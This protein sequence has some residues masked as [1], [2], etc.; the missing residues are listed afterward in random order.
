MKTCS[1]IGVCLACFC[2]LGITATAFSDHDR[3]REIV[4]RAS[5]RGA[6]EV[7]PVNSPATAR[8]RATIHD[9]GTIDFTLSYSDLSAPLAVSHIHFGQTKV[10]GGVMIFLCGGGGQPACPAATAATITGQIAA[11]NVTGPTAQG[12]NPGDLAS[13]LRIIVQQGEGYVNL[14]NSRFPAGEIRGQ[15]KAS[16]DR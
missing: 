6:D 9:D 2:A 13:A 14:H 10:S 11:A 12:V 16:F 8:F 5:A 4:L 3:D 7:P 15:V 1:A